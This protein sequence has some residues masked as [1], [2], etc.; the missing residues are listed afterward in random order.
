[1]RLSNIIGYAKIIPN[2]ITNLKIKAI[3][4]I[5]GIKLYG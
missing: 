4:F 2:N 3:E 5:G 1:M